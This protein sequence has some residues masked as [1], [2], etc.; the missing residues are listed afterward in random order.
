MEFIKSKYEEKY[1]GSVK[2]N[3]FLHFSFDWTL[4]KNLRVQDPLP[5]TQSGLCWFVDGSNIS[6]DIGS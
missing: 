4:N 5:N 1:L 2:K 3:N 6:E